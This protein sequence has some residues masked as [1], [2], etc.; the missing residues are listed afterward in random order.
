MLCFLRTNAD[1]LIIE[2]KII[3]RNQIDNINELTQ[4]LKIKQKNWIEFYFR[5]SIEELTYIGKTSKSSNLSEFINFN[6]NLTNSFKNHLPLINLITFLKKIKKSRL[7]T[8]KYHLGLIEN[9]SKI[10]PSSNFIKN[11]NF[12]LL[13]D[14]FS[15]LALI[16]DEDFI[17]LYNMSIY[18]K[19]NSK[20]F[21]KRNSKILSLDIKESYSPN[22]LDQI[23]KSYE[24]DLNKNI[25]DFFK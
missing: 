21:Y 11:L 12:T 25:E 9:L 20:N 23:I 3:Y 16:K 18:L 2:D 10:F 7:I 22:D 6:L 24:V 5:K 19:E 8:D 13:S 14:E 15:S 4:Q 1:F 17:L